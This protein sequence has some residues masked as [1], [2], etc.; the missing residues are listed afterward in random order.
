MTN[1]NFDMRPLSFDETF[2]RIFRIY[3]ER[4]IAFT[5][6][7]FAMYAMGWIFAILLSLVLGNDITIDGFSNNYMLAYESFDSWHQFLFYFTEAVLYYIFSCIAHGAGAWLT[8]QLY[9]TTNTTTHPHIVDS[10]QKAGQKCFTLVITTFIKLLIALLPTCILGVLLYILAVQRI[11]QSNVAIA[12]VSIIMV[13]LGYSVKVVLFVLYPVV[14][15]ENQLSSSPLKCIKRSFELSKGYWGHILGILLVW[16]VV[17]VVVST[18]IASLTYEGIMKGQSY[19]IY[20]AKILDTIIGIFYL[21]IM[22]IFEGVIYINL[23]VQKEDLDS[24]KLGEE[25]GVVEEGNSYISMV[26]GNI[27]I[28]DNKEST[29][30]EE[31]Q[32]PTIP[33]SNND[34]DGAQQPISGG[35]VVA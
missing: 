32:P 22:P 2:L 33:S 29:V 31:A 19:L 27:V 13:L 16:G 17:K 18:I 4:W 6:I 28:G 20:L 9:V 23:R 26:P 11:L 14:M 35:G 5:L 15:V 34:D 8:L 1:N 3:K 12:W 7:A 10:F 24:V 25:I 21:A 30:A